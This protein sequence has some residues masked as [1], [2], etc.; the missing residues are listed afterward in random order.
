MYGVF[1]LIAHVT[2]QRSTRLLL[3]AMTLGGSSLVALPL[4]SVPGYELA[5][6]LALVHGLLGGIVGITFAWQINRSTVSSSRIYVAA[7]ALAASTLSLWA[8]LIPPVFISWC[9][10][11]LS[12]C[13]PWIAFGFLPILPLFSSWVAASVGVVIGNLTT[14]RS[15]AA[16][17]LTIVIIASFANALWPILS[18]PQV[19]AYS[20]LLGYL[21][22]PLY[23][24]A[25]RLPTSLL[26]F[27]LGS[28]SL[29]IACLGA[30]AL[31]D[32][33]S[34]DSRWLASTIFA[35]GLVGFWAIEMHGTTFRF[36]MTNDELALRLSTTKQS[37]TVV[38]H[39]S[40]AIAPE[41]IQQVFDDLRFR[42]EQVSAFLGETPRRPAIVWLYAS[43]AEK[44]RLVGAANTQFAK[45]W[46]NEIHIN[47]QGFPHA[48]A[49]HELVHA[50]AAAWGAPPFGVTGRFFGLLPHMG[51]IEGLAVAADNP[52]DELSLHEW[53]AAQKKLTL[54]PDLRSVLSPTGFY[55][56]A[57]AR[58]YS[59][60]GS[61]IRWL[62]ETF[63]KEKLRQLYKHGDF[64]SVYAE[65]IDQLVD[66]YEQFLTGILISPAQQRQAE[67]RFRRGSIFERPCAREVA[68]LSGEG[69]DRSRDDPLTA[70]AIYS[71]C[72]ALQPKDPAH[73]MA[74]IVLLERQGRNSEA[75][76]RLDALLREL[77]V[78]TTS[79]GQAVLTRVDFAVTTGDE[80]TANRLL[81]AMQRESMP[82]SIDR[83]M[84]VRLAAMK[85]PVSEK[86]AIFEYLL[87]RHDE[88]KLFYL[89]QTY[90][91]QD[92]N[93]VV[94][95]LIGRRLH[96]LGDAVG[97]IEWLQ[98]AR[99]QTLPESLH[100]ETD[101]L[102]IEASFRAT[103]C[104]NV[105]AIAIDRQWGAAFQ[106]RANDWVERCRFQYQTQQSP[107]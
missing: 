35:S 47:D 59:A 1:R 38:L 92:S 60:A 73:A 27:R 65:S 74:M 31:F 90:D 97:A 61:F 86:R 85:G 89:R 71:R 102:E 8:T 14:R 30:A 106:K 72:H 53:A 57:P 25:L 84:H 17:A 99:K 88:L 41:K 10:A 36:K 83:A 101:R 81:D 105:E 103:R 24:E 66:R 2:P 67:S 33:R 29:I 40:P 52:I 94:S 13:D 39:A 50:L 75:I 49:K 44:Q 12:P 26:W 51:I 46:R 80:A 68:L 28:L 20:H 5:E 43:A 70:Y 6:T 37:N 95:Y 3:A 48:V 21:P 63:G 23:D 100:E 78:G 45:P 54:L 79:W 77:E 62:A 96:Q 22:G 9:A 55:A 16:I 107:N 34:I 93:A 11:S 7:R 42:V 82:P 58:A 98:R 87:S 64:E 56:A 19:F 91:E 69:A 4:M 76:E 32:S 18:G 104:D 15:I